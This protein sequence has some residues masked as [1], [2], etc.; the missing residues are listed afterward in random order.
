[1]A[2]DLQLVDN[3]ALFEFLDQGDRKTLAEVIGHVRLAEGETLFQAGEPGDSLF[4]VHSGEVELSMKDTAGQKILLTTAKKDDVF[5]ELALLDGEPRTATAIAVTDAELLELDRNQLLFLFQKRPEAAL[6]ILAA[7]GAMTR[8]ADELLRARVSRNV[9]EVIEVKAT[10][11]QRV[12]D[13]IAAFSGSMP[14]LIL[15]GLWFFTWIAINTLDFGLRQFDPF[16]F[17]L[18]TMIVSLEA[19]FLSCFVLI[20]QNRQA[21]KDH[22]HADIEYEVNVQAELEIKNLHEKVDLLNKNLL[23]KLARLEKAMAARSSGASS[24][25]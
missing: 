5:G 13:A 18:L 24:V 8:R 14:F 6:H 20:S 15:N 19:I 3:I 25:Q 2:C 9:N 1:M 10:V 23:D 21:E 4:I 12:A 16:P 17:G 22:V 7:M 11:L